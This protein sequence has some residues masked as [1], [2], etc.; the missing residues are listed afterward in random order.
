MRFVLFLIIAIISI[1]MNAQNHDLRKMTTKSRNEYLI[2]IAKE[3]TINFGP[4]WYNDS[5]HV[6]ISDSKIVDLEEF[7]DE[8]EIKKIEGE[9]YYVVTFYN[10]PVNNDEPIQG[11]T[12]EVLMPKWY[13]VHYK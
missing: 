12:D 9:R 2:K 7:G 3:V 8:P 11:L 4:E 6:N 13:F 1:A 5:L 10:V